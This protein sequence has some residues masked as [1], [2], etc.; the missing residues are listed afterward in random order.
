MV[1]QRGETGEMGGELSKSSSFWVS[2]THIKSLDFVLS[3]MRSPCRTL[4]IGEIL[5]ESI[6][7]SLIT[8]TSVISGYLITYVV[9]YFLICPH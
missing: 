5:I 6:N 2:Y 3:I 1:I 8:S 4:S 7:S 9:I